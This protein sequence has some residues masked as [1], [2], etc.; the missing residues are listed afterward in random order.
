[1]VAGLDLQP[2]LEDVQRA[3]E[4]GC[5]GPRHATRHGIDDDWVIEVLAL[6]KQQADVKTVFG[7]R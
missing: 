2:R 6:Q 4:H 5:D 3:H 1:M 7:H